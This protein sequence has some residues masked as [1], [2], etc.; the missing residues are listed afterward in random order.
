M[1]MVLMG[2]FSWCAQIAEK[3]LLDGSRNRGNFKSK[4][5]ILPPFIEFNSIMSLDY[6]SRA[7]K[8]YFFYF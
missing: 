4:K 8:P 5:S 1:H 3:N 2:H 6:T 7:E